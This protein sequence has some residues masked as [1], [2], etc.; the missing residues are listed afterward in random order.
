MLL[1]KFKNGMKT[2]S[3]LP[4]PLCSIVVGVGRSA[5]ASQ[6]QSADWDIMVDVMDWNSLI[7]KLIMNSQR[8]NKWKGTIFFNFWLQILLSVAVWVR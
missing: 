7:E 6:I 2:Y 5:V 4:C 8:K 3:Y 1:K